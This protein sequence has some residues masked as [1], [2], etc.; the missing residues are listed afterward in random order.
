MQEQRFNVIVMNAHFHVYFNKKEYTKYHRSITTV[1][2]TLFYY[3][4]F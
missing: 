2:L 3:V 4:E 1:T